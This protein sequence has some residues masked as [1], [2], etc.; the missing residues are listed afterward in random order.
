MRDKLAQEHQ[1]K[2]NKNAVKRSYKLRVQRYLVDSM[3]HISTRNGHDR[4][5]KYGKIII[6]IIIIIFLKG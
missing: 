6:I 4:L 2:L 5:H 3:L 1:L